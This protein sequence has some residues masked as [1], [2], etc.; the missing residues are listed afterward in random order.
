MIERAEFGMHAASVAAAR[1][2]V[3]SVLDGWS[4]EKRQLA[5]LMVSEL[6]TNAV[7]HARSCFSVELHRERDGTVYVEV[8]DRGSGVPRQRHPAPLD[9]HGRGLL[10]VEAFAD[11]WGTVRRNG[12]KTVWFSVSDG[13]PA[14]G[15]TDQADLASSPPAR[16]R[17]A[18]LRIAGAS[19]IGH[20]P[21]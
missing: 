19:A 5:E 7:K 2:F 10:I 21:P 6:A 8:A 4:T 11:E 1:H 12:G 18:E 14:G 3:A 13:L 17:N 9:P 15:I 20:A 16:T